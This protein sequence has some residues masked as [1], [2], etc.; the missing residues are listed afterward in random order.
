[1]CYIRFISVPATQEGMSLS[2]SFPSVEGLYLAPRDALTTS[3]NFSRAFLKKN[4]FSM[5]LVKIIPLLCS[6]YL[7]QAR[8]WHDTGVGSIIFEEAVSLPILPPIVGNPI[9]PPC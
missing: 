5:L 6:L 2:V 7:V 4:R 8:K 9:H 1:V 3:G